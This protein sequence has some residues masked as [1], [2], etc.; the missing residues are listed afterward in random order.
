MRWILYNMTLQLQDVPLLTPVTHYSNS[1]YNA[2]DN[3]LIY[4][5]DLSGTDREF[6]K[7]IR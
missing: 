6:T 7:S 1:T 3:N 2:F 4:W 5:A